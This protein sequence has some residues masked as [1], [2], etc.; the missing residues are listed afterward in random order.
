MGSMFLDQ[1]SMT[2][3]SNPRETFLY[4]LCKT[5]GLEHF[6]NVVLLS[7]YEDQYGP[8]Q[9][10]RAEMCTQWEKQPEKTIYCEMVRN[11]WARVQPER[12]TRLD[13]NF[14]L[15]EKN[16]DSII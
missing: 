7:C 4:R 11:L 1:M 16:I 6:Q 10:A 12:V 14:V 3:H 13:V 8:L 9:S 5:R 2:D 15:P